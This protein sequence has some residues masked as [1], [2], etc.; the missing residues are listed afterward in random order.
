[1]G[2]WVEAGQPAPGLTLPVDNGTTVGANKVMVVLRR[3]PHQ[4]APAA[5]SRVHFTDKPEPGQYLQGAV[6]GNQPDAGVLLT[7]PVI[8]RRRSQVLISMHNGT[9]YAAALRRNLI[10]V[11]PQ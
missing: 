6:Y 2:D 7:Y 3:P 10:I 8:Y 5:S 1:M 9:D 4:V 11:P